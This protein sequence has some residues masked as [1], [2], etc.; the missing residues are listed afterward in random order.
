MDAELFGIRFTF[1][2][3]YAL[4]AYLASFFVDVS[5]AVTRFGNSYKV[6]GG[7]SVSARKKL[8][9]VT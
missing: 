7:D 8:A 3:I 4:T 1:M 6:L 5:N 9:P 2:N